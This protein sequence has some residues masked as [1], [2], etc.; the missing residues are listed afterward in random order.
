[1]SKCIICKREIEEGKICPRCGS[2]L[3]DIIVA[4]AVTLVVFVYIISP[5]DVIPEAFTGPFGLTDDAAALLG[6]I[7]FDIYSTAKVIRKL[8]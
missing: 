2:I 3:K 8:C 7:G 1:M 4:V 6:I 5:I